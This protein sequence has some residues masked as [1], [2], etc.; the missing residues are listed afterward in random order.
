MSLSSRDTPESLDCDDDRSGTSVKCSA[1]S[2][3]YTMHTDRQQDRIQTT[4]PSELLNTPRPLQTGPYPASSK[5]DSPPPPVNDI[6][7][8][9]QRLPLEL[10]K[11]DV[12]TRIIP[13][14]RTTIHEFIDKASKG[15]LK[16]RGRGHPA[17][18]GR[19]LKLLTTLKRYAM[20]ITVP[21][22]QVHPDELEDFIMGI[23][24][25]T[26]PKLIM[27]R[28]T[29]TY[30]PE[31]VRDFKKIIKRFYEWLLIDQP[32]Q[33]EEL[34]GW[35]ETKRIITKPK[36]LD[37]RSIPHLARAI[38]STQGEALVWSFFDGGFRVGELMNVRL[39]RD[40]RVYTIED[41]TRLCQLNIR[42]SKTFARI[43]ALPLASDSLLFWIE[44]HPDFLGFDHDGTV[45]TKTAN[46]LL[47]QWSYRYCC[48]MFRELGLR[49]LGE[50][51]H[52]HRF[53]HT[54]ASYWASKLKRHELCLRMGWS[55]SSPQP[56]R[57]IKKSGYF[58]EQTNL[59]AIA[60]SKEDIAGTFARSE[61]GPI[62]LQNVSMQNLQSLSTGNQQNMP[63]NLC[64]EYSN[65]YENRDTK[66]QKRGFHITHVKQ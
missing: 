8:H 7:R 50:V 21:F 33:L 54:S 51:I 28:G 18:P 56:D 44:R 52:P 57:Y 62:S 53:R 17:S 45:L 37:P 19:C 64:L 65:L 55:M 24:D 63:T 41:G 39:D 27:I 42:I 11:L 30:S 14:N 6:H 46:P 43:V 12:D 15:R 60:N 61:L 40:V 32:E 59:S 49:E 2:V 34:V 16:K 58:N 4:H 48:R 29:N 13:A 31:T 23:E 38:G 9:A 20:H 66:T 35:F 36:S 26:V 25:G 3:R 1:V 10:R 5:A 47:F 22:A